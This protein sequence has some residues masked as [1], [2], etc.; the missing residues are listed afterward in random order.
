MRKRLYSVKKGRLLIYKW[1]P[2]HSEV[3]AMLTDCLEVALSTRKSDTDKNPNK[4]RKLGRATDAI[5][6]SSL[7]N[8]SHE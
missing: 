3:K 4:R 8:W 6:L 1:E 5:F 7:I 2:E